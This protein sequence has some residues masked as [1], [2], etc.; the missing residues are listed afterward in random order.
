MPCRRTV[1]KVSKIRIWPNYLV[2]PAEYDLFVR[3][4]RNM[5][6]VYNNNKQWSYRLQ[7]VEWIDYLFTSRCSPSLS[8]FTL[9]KL[10]TQRL[11]FSAPFVWYVQVSI[12]DKLAAVLWFAVYCIAWVLTCFGFKHFVSTLAKNCEVVALL[13]WF[14][15]P[16]CLDP[17]CVRHT[18]VSM[19]WECCQAIL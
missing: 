17:H 4:L 10:I 8:H 9:W 3:H 7:Y 2:W 18:R 5:N 14:R 11:D 13:Y 1:F 19:A 6:A 16:R 15:V 12:T